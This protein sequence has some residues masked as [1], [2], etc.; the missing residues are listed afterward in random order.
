[1]ETALRAEVAEVPVDLPPRRDSF[2]EV[3]PFMEEGLQARWAGQD[4]Y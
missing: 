2:A 4:G 3:H 1:M